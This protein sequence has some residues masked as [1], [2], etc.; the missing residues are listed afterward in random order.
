VFT[1]PNVTAGR[2]TFIIMPSLEELYADRFAV[3]T[4]YDGRPHIW[5]NSRGKIFQSK[6]WFRIEIPTFQSLK[7]RQELSAILPIK[8]EG[9]V[10]VAH[11]RP[12]QF[13]QVAEIMK[14]CPPIARTK[15]LSKEEKRRK[16]RL[17]LFCG[18]K[19]YGLGECHA[20]CQPF[21]THNQEVQRDR[22]ERKARLAG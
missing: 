16:D 6:G 17:C 3:R 2:L 4:G 5:C 15:R 21:W 19:M 20:Q 7:L 10:Y 1:S 11:F 14:P 22:A 9:D 18:E 13:E 8:R 12:H